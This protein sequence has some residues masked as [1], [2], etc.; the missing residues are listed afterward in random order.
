MSRYVNKKKFSIFVGINL[1]FI[2]APIILKNYLSDL[3]KKYKEFSIKDKIKFI[4][5]ALALLIIIFVLEIK[6]YKS[7]FQHIDDV[8]LHVTNEELNNL[9]KL[10]TKAAIT[11]K[12]QE[13]LSYHFDKKESIEKILE[14]LGNEYKHIALQVYLSDHSVDTDDKLNHLNNFWHSEEFKKEE[15]TTTATTAQH[16]FLTRALEN[17]GRG[18]K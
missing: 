14:V 7:S 4:V 18:L 8:V 9:Q 6:L 13:I 1:A 16:S 15:V 3:L 12:T 11:E 2:V 17:Q 5:I 10:K